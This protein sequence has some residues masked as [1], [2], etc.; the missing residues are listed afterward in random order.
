M[1]AFPSFNRSC[2]SP[3]SDTQFGETSDADKS[4]KS[5]W[6]QARKVFAGGIPQGVDQNTLYRLFS[7]YGKVKKAWLQ[8]VH[9]NHGGRSAFSDGRHR[10]F[11]FII[12]YD[13]KAVEALIG[14]DDSRFVNFGLPG[15]Y[16]EDD[17][18]LEVKPAFVKAKPGT[19]IQFAAQN[20]ERSS[21][22]QARDPVHPPVPENGYPQY[23]DVPMQ[24]P[25]QPSPGPQSYFMLIPATVGPF[26]APFP[27]QPLSASPA[28][29]SGSEFFHLPPALHRFVGHQ[30]LPREV[31]AQ[32]L[33]QG[34]PSH[35]ED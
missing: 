11:G 13:L 22:L 1:P 27:I 24:V 15:V 30:P 10:G 16:T 9:T 35:Y 19:A 26:V 32:R 25:H 2:D 6:L 23:G 5:S 14:D 28:P 20:R 4:T 29:A 17:L 31:L 7:K 33:R 21:Q 12:F 3:A 8:L 18:M 34:M